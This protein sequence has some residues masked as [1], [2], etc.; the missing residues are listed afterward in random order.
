MAATNQIAS[1][2]AADYR[3]LEVTVRDP[4]GNAV[5]PQG[6]TAIYKVSRNLSS[7][8]AL[9]IKT[10]GDGITLE[11]TGEDETMLIRIVL[12]P[13]DTA[14]VRPGRYYHE[15]EVKDGSNRPFTV[16]TGELHI[17]GTLIKSL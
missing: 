7:G 14:E 15:I 16:L 8:N 12:N 13:S 5:T 9:I 10:V 11:T 2:H 4:N 1:I 17:T 3:E 6:L